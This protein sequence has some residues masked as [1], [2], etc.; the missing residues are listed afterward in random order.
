MGFA[1]HHRACAEF[2]QQIPGFAFSQTADDL[3]YK[4]VIVPA[5]SGATAAP[6]FT[7][8]DEARNAFFVCARDVLAGGRTRGVFVLSKGGFDAL[9]TQDDYCRALQQSFP[10]PF[11]EVSNLGCLLQSCN[12]DMPQTTRLINFA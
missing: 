10:A 7:I 9:H 5:A 2:A 11:S 8:Y 6:Y 12:D 4:T 1:A 3:E